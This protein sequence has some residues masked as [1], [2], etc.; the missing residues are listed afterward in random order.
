MMARC[1]RKDRVSRAD[2]ANTAAR[3]LV[4]GAAISFASAKRKAAQQ[5]GLTE[6]RLF[7]DNLELHAAIADYQRLFDNEAHRV[8]VRRLRCEA[9]SAMKYFKAFSPRLVGP[10]LYGTACE[11][12]PVTLHLFTDEFEALSRYLIDKR[13]PYR[14][15]D[16]VFRISAARSKPYPVVELSFAGTDFELVVF[17]T[18]ELT[19]IP[20]SSLDGR[21]FER[22]KADDV[23][24]L[25]SED[26]IYGGSHLD[27]LNAGG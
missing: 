23:E 6:T 12:R 7:P 15:S 3:L 10:V 24:A 20:L 4:E 8:R 9:L 1:S 13:I 16:R 26:R 18:L 21:P 11:G 27:H 5:L 14:I 22:A 25:L 17:T 2:I 19:R